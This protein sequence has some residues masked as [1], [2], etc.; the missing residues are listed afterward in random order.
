MDMF[1]DFNMNMIINV[2][3][4]MVILVRVIMVTAVNMKCALIHNCDH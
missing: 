2:C 1:I 3:E 4:N